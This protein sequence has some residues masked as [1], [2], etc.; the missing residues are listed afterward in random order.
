SF[1]PIDCWALRRG[2]PFVSGPIG[3]RCGH[4]TG[5]PA[6]WCLCAPM[7]GQSEM[8]GVL[9]LTSAASGDDLTVSADFEDGPARR[10]AITV[11]GQM[12]MA[13]A[14]LRLRDSLREMSIRDPLTGLFNRRFM[15]ETL[16]R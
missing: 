4:L 16:D 11:A 10:L 14:N 15:E 2:R 5:S 13:F 8:M 12:S 7:V 6:S 3:P 9:H 1:A